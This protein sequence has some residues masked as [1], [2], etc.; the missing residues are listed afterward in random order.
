[1]AQEWAPYS[2][3][4]NAVTPGLIETDLV[5]PVTTSDEATRRALTG[6]ALNR[7]GQPQEV[8]DLVR[9]LVSDEASYCTGGIYPVHGGLGA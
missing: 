4:V 2:I 8:A 7:L 5:A 9:F 3:R 6:V 1:M